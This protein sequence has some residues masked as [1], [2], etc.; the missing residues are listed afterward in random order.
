[1]SNP[2]GVLDYPVTESRRGDLLISTDQ[3][4]LDIDAIHDFLSNSY[5][6]TRGMSRETLERAVRGS[7]CFGIY[8]GKRQIGFARVVT[9]G[10][11][12]AY[13]CDDYVIED[14]RGQGLGKW[15]MQSVFDHPELRELHRWVVVTRDSRLYEKFGFTLVKEPQTYLEIVHPFD[16]QPEA[17]ATAR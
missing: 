11:T 10:A 4:R 16:R 14:Y 3:S 5:W 6:E 17:G 13:L 12:F 1:M 15:L 8:D 9:D 2:S 7:L